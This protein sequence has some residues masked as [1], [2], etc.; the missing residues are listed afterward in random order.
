MCFIRFRFAVLRRT[1][2]DDVGDIHLLAPETH[3]GNHVVQQLSCAAHEGE[4]L[5][6]FIGANLTVHESGLLAVT[7]MGM[8]LAN[9]KG[10]DVRQILHFK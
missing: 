3:G 7:L 9:M 4:P 6:I 5:G 1:A 2:F 8:C 10:V